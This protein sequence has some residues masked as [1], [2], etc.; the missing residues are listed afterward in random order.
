MLNNYFIRKATLVDTNQILEIYTDAKRLLKES[1]SDQWQSGYPNLSTVTSDILDNGLYILLWDEKIIGVS[2]ITD[3]GEKTYQQIDGSWL[4]DEPY[5]VVHRIATRDGYYGMGVAQTLFNFTEQLALEK[6]IRNIRVDT[7]KQN[8]SMQSLLSKL[9]YQY[10]GIID[11]NLPKPYES[12]RL[13]YQKII[14]DSCM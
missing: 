10:C 3:Q 2:F 6:G 4:N 13:A 5:F 1:G 8:L 7:H 14:R 12:K 9:N 11:L